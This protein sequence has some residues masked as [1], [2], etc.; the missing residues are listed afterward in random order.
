M[1]HARKKTGFLSITRE[2]YLTNLWPGS[3]RTRKPRLP[4]CMD[5]IY[6]RVR[7]GMFFRMEYKRERETESC[8][9]TRR[10]ELFYYL[11][12]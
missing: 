10:R 5:G 6:T 8:L 4:S 9:N 2:R 1:L 3:L 12:N 11:V 7:Y